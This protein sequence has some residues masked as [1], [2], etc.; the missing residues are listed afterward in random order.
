M[1]GVMFTTFEDFVIDNFGHDALDALY[2][3]V[4]EVGDAVF[5]AVDSYPDAWLLALLGKACE[6]TGLDRDTAL[7]AF[8]TYTLK[9]LVAAHPVFT[10]A[11]DHPKPFLMAVHGVIHVEVH[12]LMP[13]TT[14]PSI[15]CTDTGPDSLGMEYRSERGLCTLAEGL[16]EGACEHY[17]VGVTHTHDSCKHRGDDACTWSI[18]FAPVEAAVS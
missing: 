17:G 6:M 8:G 2:D 1:K 10:D 5:V 11:H 16:L 9:K 4:P 12:K 15:L 7:R 3:A 18:Q 13:G 14:T